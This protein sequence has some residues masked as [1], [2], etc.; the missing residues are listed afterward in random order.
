[1]LSLKVH[2]LLISL[3]IL[4]P[5]LPKIWLGGAFSSW[6]FDI[7]PLFFMQF[8]ALWHSKI[9]Q[10]NLVLSLPQPWDQLFLQEA[11]VLFPGELYLEAKV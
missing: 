3:L 5:K 8:F 2:N 10:A 11:L 4:I 9:F 7:F 6:S 1:M